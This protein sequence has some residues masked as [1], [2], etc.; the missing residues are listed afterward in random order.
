[1][2]RLATGSCKP[3][4]ET[5]SEIQRGGPQ[6]IALT[7]SAGA[8]EGIGQGRKR[9]TSKISHVWEIHQSIAKMAAVIHVY[10]YK[11]M[12]INRIQHIQMELN[13]HKGINTHTMNKQ[14]DTRRQNI[15]WIKFQSI[16]AAFITKHVNTSNN[17][18][19]CVNPSKTP[20][21]MTPVDKID[22]QT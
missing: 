14:E 18:N 17:L 15:Q 5:G 6:Q 12:Y 20:N 10:K 22:S 21:S 16:S 4:L 9:A 8:A 7:P 11:N 13:A 19:F 3:T 2:A 1:M